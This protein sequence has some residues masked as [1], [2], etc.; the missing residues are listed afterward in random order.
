MN[1]PITSNSAIDETTVTSPSQGKFAKAKLNPNAGL[2]GVREAQN[3][4][5]AEESQ[6]AFIEPADMITEQEHEVELDHDLRNTDE[7]T[8]LDPKRDRNKEKNQGQQRRRQRRIGKRRRV[9]ALEDD[10]TEDDV[11][12]F[13]GFLDQL[14][15]RLTE[16]VE[17]V[18][19]EFDNWNKWFKKEKLKPPA[20]DRSRVTYIRDEYQANRS[21]HLWKSNPDRKWILAFGHN[22]INNIVSSILYKYQNETISKDA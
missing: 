5:I 4:S 14:W 21:P 8:P 2:D 13:M 9:G 6:Q 15:Q 11:M 22:K 19:E 17:D 12:G 18:A 1:A 16:L 3:P 20:P 7:F 10:Y